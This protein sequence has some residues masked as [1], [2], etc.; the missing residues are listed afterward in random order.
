MY[1]YVFGGEGCGDNTHYSP[2]D[3]HVQS[4]EGVSMVMDTH[5]TNLVLFFYYWLCS[6]HSGPRAIS[7]R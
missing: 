5:P 3:C 7:P 1:L 4:L 2:N 6:V